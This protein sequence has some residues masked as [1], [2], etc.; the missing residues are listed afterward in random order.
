MKLTNSGDMGGT[1]TIFVFVTPPST[2]DPSEPAS[3]MNYHLID[4]E[5]V[6][7]D[8]GDSFT[9]EFTLDKNDDLML[10]DVNG[11]ATL[12]AGTY[13]ISFTNGVD[14]SV[15]EEVTVSSTQKF[16]NIA[17]LPVMSKRV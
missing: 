13:T 11:T 9:Y 6:Y 7:L 3:K 15:K 16:K 14:Q 5:K 12:F 17:P 8:A 10:Y 4:W 2:L 1:E